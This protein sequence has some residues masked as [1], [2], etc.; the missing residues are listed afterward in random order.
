MDELFKNIY[1]LEVPLVGNPLKEVNDYLIRG[2]EGDFLIDTG[3]RTNECRDALFS[4]LSELNVDRKKLNVLLTHMHFDHSGLATEAAGEDG[5]IYISSTD[6]GVLLNRLTGRTNKKQDDLYREYGFPEELLERME[7]KGS[8]LFQGPV[9]IDGRFR[10][11]DDGDIV[12]AGDYELRTIVV[13]GHTPGSCM[14]WNE[15]NGIMF[16]GDHILFDITPNITCSVDMQDLLGH[17]LDSL[18]TVREY[19][20][21]FALPG[22]RKSGAYRERVDQILEH[23]RKRL[24]EIQNILAEG[25]WQ[26]AYQTAQKMKWRIES[27]SWEDFLLNQKWFAFG[28]CLSHLEYLEKRGKVE[29][30]WIDGIW[31]WNRV[32]L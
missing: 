6:Y 1:K 30:V 10:E 28:E 29:R 20:V 8:L 22:H 17:Y 3:F 15:Q 5:H 18:A 9:K 24:D 23:H 25:R 7:N 12:L 14:F 13:P 21:Q 19:P 11:L 32:S 26:T 4:Q 16:T 31:Y 27:K 2:R